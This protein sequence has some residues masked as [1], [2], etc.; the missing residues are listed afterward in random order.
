MVD[1]TFD[2]IHLVSTDPL[3]AARFYEQHFGAVKESIREWPDGRVSLTLNLKNTSLVIGQAKTN[4]ELNRDSPE[5]HYGLQH[6]GLRTNNLDEAVKELKAHGVK[7]KQE[8]TAPPPPK[9]TITPLRP[10]L[11]FAF[12]W[13]PDDVLIEL[14]N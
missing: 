3:K 12:I 10:G 11:R 14:S 13:G 4:P 7:F 6:I 1:Y 9:Q 2:H 8:I 5:G